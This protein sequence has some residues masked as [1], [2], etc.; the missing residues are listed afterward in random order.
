MPRKCV[1]AYQKN[2]K[3]QRIELV[4]I[5]GKFITKNKDYIQFS[6]IIPGLH[7]QRVEFFPH[8]VCWYK[9]GND[10]IEVHRWI[11]ESKGLI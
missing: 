7:N 1:D 3:T 10:Y 4:K 11:A 6:C 8:T 2:N 9:E 5:T